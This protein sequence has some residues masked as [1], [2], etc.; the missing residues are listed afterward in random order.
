ML[1]CFCAQLSYI[2]LCAYYV[3]NILL[4]Y[5]HIMLY[6][7][8]IIAMIISFN[9]IIITIIMDKQFWEFQLT[10]ISSWQNNLAR[11]VL[12]CVF[13]NWIWHLDDKT[14]SMYFLF[15][16]CYSFSFSSQ[17]N[18]CRFPLA[19]TVLFSPFVFSLLAKFCLAEVFD[20]LFFPA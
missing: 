6:K 20:I 16:C 14:Y 9:I 5:F 11:F 19:S 10:E 18:A 2:Q 12:P 4:Y 17:L 7:Y 8:I 1:H 3:L 13:A 15:C